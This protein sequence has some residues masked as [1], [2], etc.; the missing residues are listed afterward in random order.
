MYSVWWLLLGAVFVWLGTLTFFYFRDKN[1]LTSLFPKSGERDIRKKFSEV[2]KQVEEFA[3]KLDRLNAK[4][5]G[6][7]IDSLGH[8]QKVKLLR[9]NPYGDTGGDQS[10]TV[11][12]LDNEGSGVVITSLHSRGGTRVFAKPVEKGKSGKFQ[13]SKEENEAIKEALKT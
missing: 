4:L 3:G 7:E 11:A 8:I 2:L 13:F 10:F 1:F 5:K 12:L 9:Y 6:V